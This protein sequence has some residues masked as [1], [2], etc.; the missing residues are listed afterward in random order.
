MVHVSSCETVCM[1]A[2]CLITSNVTDCELSGY[3]QMTQV[4]HWSALVLVQLTSCS[5]Q[6]VNW[7][8]R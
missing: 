3:S 6:F 4:F 1:H 5:P 7:R 8:K 2:L